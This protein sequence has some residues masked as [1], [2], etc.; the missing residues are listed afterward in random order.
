VSP[1][2]GDR[3]TLEAE[4]SRLV[5]AERLHQVVGTCL[6]E[7][8][9]ADGSASEA[10]GSA[11]HSLAGAVELDPALAAAL[12]EFRS[13]LANLDEG[14]RSL[15]AYAAS[16]EAEPG[17]LEA[18]AGRLDALKSLFRKYGEDEAAVLA[19]LHE[20]ES[21]LAALSSADQDA[22]EVEARL[23]DAERDLKTLAGALTDLR[24]AKA[25][26]FEATVV[27]EARELAM[28]SAVFQVRIE[29]KAVETDGADSVSFDF[30][31]NPGEAPRPLAKTASGGETS[32]LMLAI[33]V[34]SAGRA[35]VPTLV[36][37]EVDTGL[38]GRAAAVT[39]KKLKEL[40]RQRQVIVITHLP[41]IAG[42]ADVHVRIDKAESQGRTV[43][44]LTI[45]DAQERLAE[46]ARLLAGE[47]V[48][49][50]ALANARELIVASV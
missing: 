45:L 46:V 38:S 9:D 12:Q 33:K 15:S 8:V 39:A 34:A 26:E 1:K 13:A 43:T 18:A 35:G 16:L 25:S 5:H 23:A 4:V 32:R 21:D 42:Q 19:Y 24:T 31:A 50:S 44:S 49:E 10:L 20:A 37:D 36:F 28:E 27:R 7:L 17:A 40:S 3:E 41:Q 11:V 30:S 2:T 22:G 6:E 29:P 14:A 48:G 47:E